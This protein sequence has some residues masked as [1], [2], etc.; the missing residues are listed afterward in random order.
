MEINWV[1]L[2]VSFIFFNGLY[3]Q[4][5][6]GMEQQAVEINTGECIKE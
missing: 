3:E 5:L 2:F 4:F 6:F 1:C